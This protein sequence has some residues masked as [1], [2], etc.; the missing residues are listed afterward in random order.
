MVTRNT[1]PPALVEP[2]AVT[3]PVGSLK[4]GVCQTITRRLIKSGELPH[5]RIG[6]RVLI[7]M[8]SLEKFVA[9]RVAKA[10]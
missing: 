4:L 5:L 6:R 9:D 8:A 2:L 10:C 3:V 7:P 1:S